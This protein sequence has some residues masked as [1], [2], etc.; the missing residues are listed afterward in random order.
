MKNKKIN[1]V[2]TGKPVHDPIKTF[3]HP[4]GFKSLHLHTMELIRI[5]DEKGITLLVTTKGDS[6]G[7]F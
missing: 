4:S 3:F 2:P 7:T 6:H 1:F 5:A